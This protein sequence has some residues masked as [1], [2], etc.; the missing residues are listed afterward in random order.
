MNFNLKA[1]IIIGLVGL[2]VITLTFNL[3][4]STRLFV[5]DK[6]SYIF[7]VGLREAQGLHDQLSYKSREI[8]LIFSLSDN[9]ESSTLKLKKILEKSDEILFLGVI[10]RN[11]MVVTIK[12]NSDLL[13][14]Q[15]SRGLLLPEPKVGL[16]F[17][18]PHKYRL[19]QFNR[20][21]LLDGTKGY[22]YITQKE[23]DTFNFAF[24]TMESIDYVFKETANFKNLYLDL[25][26]K[27]EL[28]EKVK[29]FPG[30]K[31]T[32]EFESGDNISLVSF[33][34]SVDSKAAILTMMSKASAFK[35]TESLLRQTILFGLFLLGLIVALGVIFSA[36]L[37][38]PIV[39]LTRLADEFSKGNLK[40]KFEISTSD[41]IAVLGGAFNHMSTE[42]ESLLDAKAQMIKE[43][44]A[45]N[46]KLED[47]SKNLEKM[48]EQR[49]IE[50][51][52]A[53]DFMSAMVNSLDQGLLVIDN[54]LACHDIHT[55]ACER[56]F[57]INPKG[58]TFDQVMGIT[59]EAEI[60]AVRDW[61]NLL[62]MEMLPFES[63]SELGPKSRIV[64]TD[65]KD[66]TFK[67][68]KIDYYPMRNEEE[69]IQNLV[70]VATDKT[71][72]IQSE[73]MSREREA[74]VTMVIKILRNKRG[75]QSFIRDV[76]KIFG[77]LHE[78]LLKEDGT[79]N[80]E[81]AMMLLHT[82]NGSFGLYSLPLL[83]KSAR[84]NETMVSQAR[85]KIIPFETFITEFS[86]AVPKLFNDFK[87]TI[88]NLDKALNSNFFTGKESREIDY[89]QIMSIKKV[90][91]SASNPQLKNLFYET[92]IYLPAGSF[93][94]KY[95]DLIRKLSAKSDKR[96]DG[97]T[98]K[99]GE[100]RINPEHFDELFNVMV[101][102]FR[103][104]FDHGIE[105]ES[106]RS[107]KGK[108]PV[109]KIEVR[110][111]LLAD[112]NDR[113][114]N[115]V[116]SDDG[117][118]IDPEKIK[119]KLIKMY[120]EKDFTNLTEKEL[121]DKIFDP[122]FSTRDE[123]SALSGRGVGMSAV[124]EIVD[125]LGGELFVSSKVGV[126]SSFNFLIPIPI[127]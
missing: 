101:H 78:G 113:M 51:K 40:D 89:E 58:K 42:I 90:I 12:E 124:K 126:G 108:N 121:I 92:F 28:E 72:E 19:T 52:N 98:L 11:G 46:L 79:F 45:A 25:S 102:L 38:H 1:K 39:K 49:T 103:N 127:E 83:Q 117:A 18:E 48:V 56:L 34:K 35:F 17:L 94:E 106:E 66:P 13:E 100:I 5:S 82:L 24:L 44:E 10:D 43:L 67:H 37:V 61:A 95:D 55:K 112:K 86:N 123:V 97:V 2:L 87:E 91:D 21:T 26:L 4:Y 23:V 81:L 115:I 68:V 80:F 69:K 50:L 60:K 119:R 53:N 116:V 118:G 93:F 107:S 63:A 9:D 88:L 71:K 22:L 27:S 57:D 41:E 32:F 110:F 30:M 6:S 33:I 99:N 104:C 31:G 29:S 75:F 120:P 3:V 85:N 73:E 62:F 47:Y 122:F 76:V 20:A 8:E 111:E 14:R 36:G 70:V 114:L 16:K 54:Q 65:F 125:K 105:N 96:V 77:Q 74:Y 84:E 59:G 64:G 109:G 15:K 7:E